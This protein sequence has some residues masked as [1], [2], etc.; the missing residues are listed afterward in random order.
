ME[1]KVINLIFA[2]KIGLKVHSIN[3]RAQKIKNSTIKT[4]EIVVASV[5]IENKFGK[6]QFF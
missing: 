6:T 1:V 4:F 5:Q 3:I 2:S